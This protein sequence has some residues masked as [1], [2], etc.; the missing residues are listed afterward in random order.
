MSS[1]HTAFGSYIWGS[2]HTYATEQCHSMVDWPLVWTTVVDLFYSWQAHS[3]RDIPSYTDWVCNVVQYLVKLRQNIIWI[4]MTFSVMTGMFVLPR[5]VIEYWPNHPL[6]SL[7][8]VL[9]LYY[10]YYTNGIY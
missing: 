9:I 1:L 3:R 5:V 6:F 4:Y 2:R 7:D 8:G 10:W